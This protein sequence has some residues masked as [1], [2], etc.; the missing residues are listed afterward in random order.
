MKKLI[1]F[2]LL[3]FSHLHANE[4]KLVKVI[5]GLNKPWSL[6][7]I[8]EKDILVTEKSGNIKYIDL[9]KKIINN[10]IKIQ[11]YIA[12]RDANNKTI[13]FMTITNNKAKFL[14]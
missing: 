9:E 11:E 13:V 5:S 12:N 14:I 1:I 8:N 6:S 10:V 2:I 4:F 3:S 7:F